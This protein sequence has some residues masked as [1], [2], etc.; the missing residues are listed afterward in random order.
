MGTHHKVSL[1]V[2]AALS[3]MS[4][5][6]A[7]EAVPDNEER[8]EE[9]TV[10]G[11]SVSYANNATSE[12]MFKQQANLSSV[13]A[14]VD[15]LPGVLINEGD[16]F[17]ADDWSTSIV[18][19]GFQVNLNEQ[20]IGMTVDG[21]ANGNSNYGGGAK[22][23]RYIDT[24]NVKGVEVSQGTADIASRSHEALGGTLN[25]TTIDPAMEQGLVTS[26][27]AGEFDASKYYVR[28]ETGEIFKD[29]FAWIS[30]SSQESSDFM[31]QAAENTRDHVAMKI[32][33]TVNDVALTG[34]VS[35][36]DTHEDNY[37][38]IY[39][40]AQYEQ[41]PHWDQLTDEWTGVPY[42]DQAYRRGWSTL[43]EN[44][45][46]YL[47]A[48]F[49]V[50][51]V[52]VTT[53]AYYHDNE[54]R[55]DWVPPY[56]VDV[57]ND[58]DAGHSELVNGNTVFGG[59]ALGQFYFV[60]RAG[61]QL[62]P[63]E[64]CA[65]ALTFP[66]GGA[67]AEYDPGCH[68]QGA[69]P[70]GS[71]RHTHYNK[72]RIGFNADAIW[73][74][75]IGEF[76]NTM[77]FGIW[78]EDYERDESRDWHKI[79]NSAI[80]Y[81]FNQTPYWVQYDRSFPVDTLMYY[82]ED[83]LD[84]GLARVRLGAKKFNVDIAKNDNFDASND[85]DVNTDSDTLLSAGIVAPLPIEGLEVFAGYGENFAAIKDAQLE[86][87]DTDLRFIKPETADNIDVGFRYASPG[88]NAS[89]TYYNIGFNDRIQFTSNETSTGIDF[90]EAAA[91][92]YRN[93]GGIESSGIEI[94]ADVMLTDT[95]SLFTSV[96]VS[97]SEYIATIGGTGTQ[98]D[99][100]ADAQAAIADENNPESSLV[101]VE[102]NTVIGTPDTMA[103][104]SLDWAK[105]N[106]FAG[107][108]TK[109]VDSRFLDIYN[110]AEVEDYIVSDLYIGGFVE[111]LGQGID[112]LE[113]RL[114]VNNLFDEDYAST[115]A[116]GAFWIGAPR[117]VAVNARLTF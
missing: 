25:F 110:S 114:T 5:A 33:S 71:Y 39:G 85:L 41:N 8:I 79:T 22:A 21:I 31:Q 88:F 59:A 20:Q 44:L 15:N 97:E 19:R 43:R 96:T 16:T 92:G 83:E 102:G 12:D 64:G 116:P 11:R 81:D 69:I 30:L 60:D 24:E 49:S 54:G 50:G 29:T 17:G 68:E 117:A 40:L 45:F 62:S 100:L 90:L 1:A 52:D 95:L 101:A 73:F 42:Q 26:V 105:D 51:A 108:S 18:I 66:Y 57:A 46:A 94:S 75:K 56:L 115:I 103:V 107:I 77:R 76:D 6:T 91:G 98:Y 10:V 37:Q 9:I 80:S 23:N 109:Y 61:N 2:L 84:L 63:I 104:V 48:D 53:N 99:T 14:A 38:R 70:V 27:T 7:E 67:G 112:E 74:T 3:S 55:G 113:V 4:L 87:D 13:L 47:Q 86:R 106:Y 35:Y 65:S 78:W 58:G 89:V 32:I 36:D 72:Q 111:N 82:I 28:Y 93:V 34:Y